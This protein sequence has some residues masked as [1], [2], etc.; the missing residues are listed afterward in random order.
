MSSRSR[1]A[2]RSRANGS[3]PFGADPERAEPF[4]ADAFAERLRELVADRYEQFDK[5]FQP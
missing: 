4:A 2:N 3:A 1:S 5:R